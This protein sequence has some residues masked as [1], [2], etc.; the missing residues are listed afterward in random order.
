MK[1]TKLPY[2]GG[3]VRTNAQM[4]PHICLPGVLAVPE[5]PADDEE[6]SIPIRFEAQA[7][8]DGRSSRTRALRLV[9]RMDT[10][11]RDP[12]VNP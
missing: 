3:A 2:K 9:K 10:E 1:I 7:S 8:L 6:E 4:Q 5:R 12:G 11:P